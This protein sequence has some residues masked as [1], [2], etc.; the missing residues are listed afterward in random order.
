M[1]D[2][3]NTNW[4]LTAICHGKPDQIGDPDDTLPITTVIKLSFKLGGIIPY[5]FIYHTIFK[6]YSENCFLTKFHW[7]S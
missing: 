1:F 6:L 3:E 7:L 5:F 2:E 4:S